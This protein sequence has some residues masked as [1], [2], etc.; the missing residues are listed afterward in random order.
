MDQV[1]LNKNNQES[2]EFVNDL[3]IA[4]CM[5]DD[6]LEKHKPSLDSVAGLYDKC[7]NF[8]DFFL[9]IKNDGG[10]PSNLLIQKFRFLGKRAWLTDDTLSYLMDVLTGKKTIATKPVPEDKLPKE[11]SISSKNDDSSSNAAPNEESLTKATGHTK[12]FFDSLK[13]GGKW[14][15]SFERGNFKKLFVVGWD[16]LWNKRKW[17]IGI[18]AVIAA[19]IILKPMIGALNFKNTR[20]ELLQNAIAKISLTAE[21][22]TVEYKVKLAH[23]EKDPNVISEYIN[24]ITSFFLGT[25]VAGERS[26]VIISTASL[27][28][29]VDLQGFSLENVHIDGNSIEVTLPRARLLSRNIDL[30]GTECYLYSGSWRKEYTLDETSKAKQIAEV[31]LDKFV[32]KCNIIEEAQKNAEDFFRALL[33]QLGYNTIKFN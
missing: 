22:G 12:K 23:V 29:G 15:L 27:K 3:I 18:A 13:K 7:K 9:K 4:V 6:V 8:V 31:E 5:R 25:N 28:A 14:Q 21:L 26:M 10:Q 19:I 2:V 30:N 1:S 17:I 32:S 16:F 24:N 33:T 11:V 20:E